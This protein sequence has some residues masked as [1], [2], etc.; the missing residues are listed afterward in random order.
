MSTPTAVDDDTAGLFGIAGVMAIITILAFVTVLVYSILCWATGTINSITGCWQLGLGIAGTTVVLMPALAIGLL[1][2]KEK[3]L[4]W[5]V[6]ALEV[7]MFVA[8]PILFGSSSAMLV[9]ILIQCMVT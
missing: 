7:M 9:V 1:I 6:T 2:R 8:L 3:K 4:P 5:I